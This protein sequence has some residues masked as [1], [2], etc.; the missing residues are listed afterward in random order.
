MMVVYEFVVGFEAVQREKCHTFLNKALQQHDD[1]KPFP[2][3]ANVLSIVN[4]KNVSTHLLDSFF[5]QEK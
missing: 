1:D 2:I 3:F 4:I 5:S